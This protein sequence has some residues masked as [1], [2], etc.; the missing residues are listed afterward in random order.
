R[1]ATGSAFV[2]AKNIRP[3][4]EAFF[5]SGASTAGNAFPF[6]VENCAR[7]VAGDSLGGGRVSGFAANYSSCHGRHA[8]AESDIL[9]ACLLA[10]DAGSEHQRFPSHRFCFW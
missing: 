4:R 6:L 5:S 3:P 9:A 10:S 7:Q 2:I 1:A 8:G